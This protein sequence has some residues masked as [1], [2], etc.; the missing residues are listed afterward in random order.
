MLNATTL[1][2]RCFELCERSFPGRGPETSK[3]DHVRFPP[4]IAAIIESCLAKNLL[5]I[6]VLA[7]ATSG[8]WEPSFLRCSVVGLVWPHSEQRDTLAH[9]L[10]CPILWRILESLSIQPVGRFPIDKLGCTSTATDLRMLVVAHSLYHSC[11]FNQHVCIC[12]SCTYRELAYKVDTFAL[13]AKAAS[14]NTSDDHR[15]WCNAQL[16]L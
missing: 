8:F 2:R 11:K 4:R 5:K 9:Y 6:V 14:Q 10:Q 3:T 16:V 1:S 13:V 15:I 7:A 12:T